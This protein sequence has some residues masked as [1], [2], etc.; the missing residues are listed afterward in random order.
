MKFRHLTLFL[1]PVEAERM[2]GTATHG[3]TVGYCRSSLPGLEIFY[4]TPGVETLVITHI[5]LE[6][7]S[8]C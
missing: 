1:C 2:G 7:D 8:V 4:C 5:F 6:L 3:F